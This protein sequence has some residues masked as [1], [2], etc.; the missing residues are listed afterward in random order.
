M[1]ARRSR[2][3]VEDVGHVREG[4]GGKHVGKSQLGLTGFDFDQPI[5]INKTSHLHDGV[6]WP[7]TSEKLAMY[8]G[9]LF[10]VFNSRQQNPGANYI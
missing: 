9:D 2:K 10:L 5:R 4:V 1:R 6:G 7:R 8:Q 3:R